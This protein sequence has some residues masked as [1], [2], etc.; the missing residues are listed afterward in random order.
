MTAQRINNKPK[1]E[2]LTPFFNS[3]G[4]PYLFPHTNGRIVKKEYERD[5]L[6]ILGGRGYAVDVR[7]VEKAL[8]LGMMTL[9]IKEKTLKGKT[10]VYEV[11]LSE[12][13]ERERPISVAGILRYPVYL[14]RCLLTSGEIEPWQI[15]EREALLKVGAL[16]AQKQEEAPAQL[17]LF[18][19]A[20]LIEA[21]AAERLMA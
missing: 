10:R 1:A 8:S 17:G 13:K 4:K 18:D 15:A 5:R 6:R 9:C 21:A 7:D 14:S 16:R 11:Q 19:H 12:I 3:R 2:A 20:E